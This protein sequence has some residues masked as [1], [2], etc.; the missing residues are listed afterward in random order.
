[1]FPILQRPRHC[2]RHLLLLRPKLE[3]LRPRQNAGGREN[4]PDLGN[5]INAAGLDF[6]KRNHRIRRIFAQSRESR[7]FLFMSE[8]IAYRTVRPETYQALLAVHHYLSKAFPDA[9]LRAL[10]EIRAS[11]INGCAYCLDLHTTEARQ[12]GETQQRLDCLAAWRESP[13][14]SERE[15]AALA[16]TEA[17]THVAETRVP[18]E[19]Y[20]EVRKH[21]AETELVDLTAAIGMINLWNR[22][23]IAFRSEPKERK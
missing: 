12:L 14:F 3:I 11:Q 9:K 7:Y 19:I 22:L 20:N 21:F 15:R 8:R 17:I 4:F 18:D 23:S 6:G 2:H 1:M 16:W 10:I 13:F 5:Q